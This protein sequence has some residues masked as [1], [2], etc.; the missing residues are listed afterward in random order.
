M[1]LSEGFPVGAWKW[2]FKI[3]IV[4]LSR[5]DDLQACDS[6]FKL[7]IFW[8]V[9]GLTESF[10]VKGPQYLSKDKHINTGW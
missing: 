3:S 10:T 9:K 5:I 7:A 8:I 2:R 4:G 1:T 6:V